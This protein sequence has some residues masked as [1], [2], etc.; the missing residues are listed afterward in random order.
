MEMLLEE[1]L[2]D[3]VDNPIPEDNVNIYQGNV[4]STTTFTDKENPIYDYFIREGNR[5]ASHR[6]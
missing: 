2:V 1:E 5:N 6:I 3:D 4:A